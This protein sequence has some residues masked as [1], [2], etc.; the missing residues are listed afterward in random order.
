MY[1]HS[2]RG[3]PYPGLHQKQ[4]G[5]HGVGGDSA[6]LL[7]SGESPPGVLRRALEP[8]A[9]ERHGPV[10]V[11]PEQ[12]H[13][14]DQRAAT[15][16]LQEKAERVGAV[17]PGGEK[18][19]RRPYCSLPVPEGAC[20]KAGEELFTRAYSDST[21]GNGFKLKEGRLVKLFFCEEINMKGS[22]C[23]SAISF[24]RWSKSPATCLQFLFSSRTVEA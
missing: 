2:P 9:Q 7:H 3:Q 8:S 1:T 17:Q 16:H 4:C 13:K 22:V 14:N 21:R 11:G 24:C 12:S 20:K 10:G 23:T 6:P 5:Q 19:P 15:H 18:A